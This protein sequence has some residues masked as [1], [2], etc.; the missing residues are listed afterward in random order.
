MP[1]ESHP[2][3]AE[4]VQLLD[5]MIHSLYSNRDV[6]LRELISNASDAIDR[7]R[8][9]GLTDSSL[10]GD[11]EPLITLHLDAEKRVLAV[12]D[13]GIGMTREEVTQNLGTLAHSGSAE[14]LAALEA[15][16]KQGEAAPGLIGQFGVGFYASFMVASRVS[17]V[18]RKA[19]EEEGTLWESAGDGQ[20]TVTE[21]ARE[22][23]GTT[24]TLALRE[25]E[26][27][28]EL[29]D[30]TNEWLLRSIV[31]RYSDFVA[32]P[33]QLRKADADPAETP[34][35]LNSMKAI[36]TRPDDEVEE[37][38]R[39]E[40]YKHVSHDWNDP[41]LHVST[42]IEGNFEARALLF[43]PSVAPH[44]L[45]HHE[46][47]HRGI[48]LYVK[49]V[50]IMDECR[51]L[52]PEYLRFVRGVVEAE[53]LSLNVSRE[54]LQ[55]DAQ[56]KVIRKHLVRKILEALVDLRKRDAEA[57]R[58]FWEQF[59]P[60]IKEGLLDVGEKRERIYELMLCAS[61]QHESQPASLDEVVERMT[62]GQEVLYY[63]AAESL[64]VA[65]RSPH[66]EAFRE[67]GVEVVLF[68][69]PVDEVWLQRGPPDFEGKSWR[70][71]GEGEIDLAEGDDKQQ[72]EAERE[73]QAADYGTLL[74]ALRAALQEQVS[75]VRL[76]S[77][78]RDS[79]ACLVREEGE[80]SPQMAQI[81]RQ[82]GREVPETK[83]ILEVNAGHALLA[84]LK[85]RVAAEP[86]DDRIAEYA[87]LLF[88]QALLSEG[89]RLPDPAAFSR[90]LG[91]LMERAL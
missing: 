61:T 69:D 18:T 77:R 42:R 64:E 28:D 74:K 41:L 88:A 80:L 20:F 23:P 13:T 14:F 84:K 40:F 87:E 45:Y 12:E 36:W 66:L 60:V 37:E 32:Y 6:F 76:S 26:G 15:S 19:G 8:F 85:E 90:R 29:A 44:D 30:Y 21:V 11:S 79:A 46:N 7:R 38:E 25:V 17:V 5:L 91:E 89:G 83:P 48:Q 27:E 75:E 3:Q 47:A 2:F 31:K 34:E 51:E 56:I 82:A 9:A 57:Y 72:A 24:V 65:R 63:L 53:D 81:L 70:S 52:M 55:Q 62:E 73:E 43:V 54:I 22:E 33:I 1:V 49:R 68:A 10:Q 86:G 71:V 67:R 50:F 59:G 4:V 39:K 16:R 78:L 35:A 58:A